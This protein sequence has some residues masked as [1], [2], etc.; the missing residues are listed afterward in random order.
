MPYKRDVS[1][2][3]SLLSLV[4][5]AGALAAWVAGLLGT[6]A[7]AIVLGALAL[8]LTLGGAAYRVD[9][10]RARR[11]LAV[12]VLGLNLFGLVLVLATT[13]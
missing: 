8:G 11:Q 9:P 12:V 13:L 7:D 4:V 10:R 3:L 5:G 2:P 6:R 1:L